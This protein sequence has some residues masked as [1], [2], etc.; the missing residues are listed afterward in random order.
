MDF[1]GFPDHPHRGFET[2]TYVLTGAF[3]HEDFCGNKGTIGPGD[4]Q[5]M[6]AGRGIVH[7]EMPFG[8]EVSHGLQLWVNLAR[9]DKL[10]EPSY[11]D[12]KDKQIPRAE[13]NGVHVKVI[14][15]E[16]MG[17]KSPIYTRTPVYYLDFK[18]NAGARFEQPLPSDWN[19]FIFILA[20]SGLFGPESSQVEASAHHTLIL[21]RA[22]GEA[23]VAFRNNSNADLRF[24]LIAGKPI[25]EPIVQHGPFVMTTDEE[26][27]E[28]FHDYRHGENGF[29]NAKKWES[30]YVK[31]Q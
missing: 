29:E 4:L 25:N 30:D 19:A 26:I 18:L 10:I 13:H 23:T 22:G 9:K 24:V 6:T 31:S 16:S 14:A 15:G 28:A 1:L 5:W 17:I 11:Q 3:C 8:S 12:L 21:S 20:G 2:V 27:S 7:C